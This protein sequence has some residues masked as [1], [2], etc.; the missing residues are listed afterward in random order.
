VVALFFLILS[1][2]GL[3]KS[4]LAFPLENPFKANEKVALGI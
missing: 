2:N 1:V 3:P 4:I